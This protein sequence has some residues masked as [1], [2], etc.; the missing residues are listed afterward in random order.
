MRKLLIVGIILAAV[1]AYLR[2]F[3]RWAD[4]VDR[5]ANAERASREQR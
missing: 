5:E 3:E 4:R 2:A 1:V